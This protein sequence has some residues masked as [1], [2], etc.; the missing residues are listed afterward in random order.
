MIGEA[1]FLDD[2]WVLRMESIEELIRICDSAWQQHKRCNGMLYSSSFVGRYFESWEDIVKAAQEPWQEGLD[3]V[4]G[5]IYELDNH[6][7]EILPPRDRRRK[8]RFTENDGED[9]D[10]DR[11]RNGQPDFWVQAQRQELLGPQN[12]TVICNV[13]A[14]GGVS[15]DKILWRGAAAIVL[16]DYLEKAGYR[17]E[18]WASD[19]YY[20]SPYLG[21][22]SFTPLLL[23]EARDPLDISMLVTAVS[24]WFFRT[25]FGFQ[26]QHAAPGGHLYPAHYGYGGARTISKDLSCVQELVGVNSTLITIDGVWS[27]EQA[28]TKIK[29]VLQSVNSH[30]LEGSHV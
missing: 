29:E 15:H 16:S 18:L 4:Q 3:I 12:I 8:R 21:K 26:L 30:S 14:N 11:L 2:T 23:K 10:L 24:G 28:L 19:Y 9:V 7:H 27:Q 17:V 25:V 5:M 20:N 22:Y 6:A 13:S 1:R